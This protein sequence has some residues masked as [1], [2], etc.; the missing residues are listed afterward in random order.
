MYLLILLSASH[1]SPVQNQTRNS[2]GRRT[3][4]WQLCLRSIV[5]ILLLTLH[6]SPVQAQG[7]TFWSEQERIP[8]YLD[9]TEEPPYII[10]DMNRTIHAFNSQPLS[11]GDLDAPS[12]IFYRQWTP[13][14]GWTYPNDILF[15]RDGQSLNMLGATA[16]QSGRVHLIVLKN[17]SVYY[18]QN[19][20]ADAG[21]AVTWPEPSFIAGNIS[22]FGPGNEIVSA[23]AASPDGNEI[24][25]VLAGQENGNGLYF[26][27]SS[28]GGST[29][30][31]PYPVYLTGDQSVVVT[32][33][34]LF[35]GESGLFHAVWATFM[36]DGNGG[37]GYY[38]NYD[39]KA[40]SWSEPV[41]LDDPGIRT[42]SVIETRNG[43]IVSYYHH[44]VNGNWWRRS[45]DGGKSWS[46]PEQISSQHIGT[47]GQVSFAV[48]SN[49]VLH[50]FFGERIDDNNHGMW[51][52]TFS[53]ATWENLE[54]VVRGPQRKE[55][56]GG[57]GFDP[58]SARA[59]ILNGSTVLVTWGTDGFAGTN[60]AWYSHKR[61][62]APELPL[63]KLESPTPMTRDLPTP[64]VAEP[65]P[66][67]S[68]GST[69]ES[70]SNL[71]EDSPEFKQNPQT[72]IFVGVIPALLLVVGMIVMY[73]IVMRNK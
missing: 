67:T 40:K 17:G 23:V 48:D 27:N 41:E 46:L 3:G 29:W 45:S 32:D 37:P 49:D 54:A 51:H 44:N 16:D 61:L 58:R 28:D 31:D 73:Y 53:G 25:V 6:V 22:G 47:N 56:T 30:S 69:A 20:L 2:N 35:A 34:K 10:P 13:E 65:I 52:A 57:N 5:L 8:E 1:S 71:F 18:T 24:L 66:T 9:S 60:G 68:P 72:A 12:A 14:N 55:G 26:T 38:A 21:S 59:A 33:P 19:Y 39:P 4:F 11:L 50:A 70:V 64:V 63:V 36:E 43:V 42:P 15:D 62:N 7:A